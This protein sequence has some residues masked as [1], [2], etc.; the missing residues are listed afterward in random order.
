ML[1]TFQSLKRWKV[2]NI[3]IQHDRAQQ[4]FPSCELVLY[5][6]MWRYEIIY[7]QQI[8]LE[9]NIYHYNIT[10]KISSYLVVIRI[11]VYMS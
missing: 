1:V 11:S 9:T 5:F 8:F 7:V 4:Q 2:S 3:I 10:D 6:S